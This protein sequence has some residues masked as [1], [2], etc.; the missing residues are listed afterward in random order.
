MTF[1]KSTHFGIHVKPS[2]FEKA[3]A[4]YRKAFGA[5][6]KSRTDKMAELV[7]QGFTF[8]INASGDSWIL[9][10]FVPTTEKEAAKQ[11]LMNMGCELL[12]VD[13]KSESGHGFF[14]QDPFGMKFHIYTDPQ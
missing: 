4:F 8:W 9:H 2:Q 5:E 11:H 13:G 3:I 14:M 10:E 1:K 12:P 7:G 6:E